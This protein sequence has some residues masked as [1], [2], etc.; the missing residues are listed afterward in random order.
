MT[1]SPSRRTALK[2]LAAA[3]A[4]ATLLSACAGEGSGSANASGAAGGGDQ[5]TVTID[6]ATYNPL[7]LIIRKKGWLETALAAEG[8]KVEW[9]K[10]A[11][12]NKANEA[13]RS[14]NPPAAGYCGA[15][16]AR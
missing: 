5:N 11:G 15:G 6:Y 13:L 4:F 12:S 14:G 2:S 7:S 16:G 9:V 10:S 1:Y 8:K 3:A